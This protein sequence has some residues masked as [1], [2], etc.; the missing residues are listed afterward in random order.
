MS[1]ASQGDLSSPALSS[2]RDFHICWFCSC[3]QE[4]RRVQPGPQMSGTADSAVWP[5]VLD[6][7]LK[8]SK[9]ILSMETALWRG[10]HQYTP[11]GLSGRLQEAQSGVEVC[12]HGCIPLHTCVSRWDM[13]SHKH[14]S[15]L[16]SPPLSFPATKSML[17]LAQPWAGV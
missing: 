8:S 1:S 11:C 9:K 15:S 17:L 14:P 4:G 5:R 7:A 13:L 16:R 2:K 10:L 12:A 3:E 6:E